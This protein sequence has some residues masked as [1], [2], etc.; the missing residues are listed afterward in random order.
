MAGNFPPLTPRV[1]LRQ[2]PAHDP[3]PFRQGPLP[4]HGDSEL[5]SQSTASTSYTDL[6]TVGPTITVECGQSVI[7]TVSGSLY[8]DTAGEFALMSFAISGATTLAAS[9]TFALGF[10]A[11]NAN[12]GLFASYTVIAS[13]TPGMNTFTAKYRGTGGAA[14]FQNRRITVQI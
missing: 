7:V 1:G 11:P 2:N 8:N 13:T 12:D 9:D 10:K 4:F 3:Y 14:A 5:A 6:A